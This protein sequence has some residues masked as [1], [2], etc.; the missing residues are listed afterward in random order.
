MHG[1]NLSTSLPGTYKPYKYYSIISCA[2]QNVKDL[3]EYRREIFLYF[4][5]FSGLAEHY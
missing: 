4:S 1:M 3:T 2:M 5:S